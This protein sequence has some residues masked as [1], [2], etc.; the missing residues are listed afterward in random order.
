MWLKDGD[1]NSSLFHA[2]INNKRR[3]NQI[4]GIWIDNI[5]YEEDK[6]LRSEISKYFKSLFSQLPS[7]NP[8]LDG[9][10][11]RRLSEA[12]NLFMNADFGEEEIRSAVWNC[13]G[14]KS[15]GPDGFNYKFFQACWEIVKQD[16][17]LFIQ[18]FHLNGKLP[19]GL[20]SSFIALIPK[21]SSPNKIQDFRPISLVGSLYKILAKVLEERLKGVMSSLI[22]SSQSAFIQDRNILDATVI[23]NE[24]IH[25]AK[26]AKDGCLMLK[27]DFEKAYDSVDW[28]FLDYMLLIMGFSNKWRMWIKGCLSS[29][30]MLVLVNGSSSDHFSVSK[31]LRQGDPMAPFLFIIIAEGFAGLVRN[32]KNL[33]LFEG[34]KVGSFG[35]KVCDLQFADDTILVCKPTYSNLWCVKTILRCFEL[36]SGLKVN[37]HKSSLFAIWV[38]DSFISEAAEFLSCNIGS[39]PFLYL[40]IPVG[41]NPRRLMMWK[42]TIDLVTKRLASWKCK[43]ISFGGRLVL[44]NSVLATIPTY[45]F[46]LYKAPKKIIRKIASLQ[47][48]FL[49]GHRRNGKGIAWVAWSE[50]CKPKM[51]GGLGVKDLSRFNA[52]LLGKWRWHRLT[53][54][55]ALWVKIIDSKYGSVSPSSPSVSRWWKD[56]CSIDTRAGNSGSWFDSNIWKEVRDGMQTF[57]WED[58]WMGTHSLKEVFPGLF[59][60]AFD[61]GARVADCGHWNNASWV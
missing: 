56:L 21:I 51:Q 37:A 59:F 13:A 60:L 22:S 14:D 41:A 40:G 1:A 33:G 55:D 38:Q 19:R 45:H 12:Q 11:F 42:G 3:R 54:K 36:A 23:I 57:F 25:S 52:A 53:E 39:I 24:T 17:I 34:Y 7:T 35:I 43:H 32:A 20:N 18:E 61:G 44:V 28:G 50:V 5:W 48:N 58:T 47:R 9:V 10:N 27:V 4:V 46:S 8:T 6:L 16:I 29:T 30:S 26:K 15:P 2:C 31:G 49:W